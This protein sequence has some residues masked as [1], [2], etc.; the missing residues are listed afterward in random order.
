MERI[1][2]TDYTQLGKDEDVH[3]KTKH[4]KTDTYSST[5]VVYKQSKPNTTLV[6]GTYTVGKYYNNHV[7]PNTTHIQS[8]NTG[9]KEEEEQYRMWEPWNRQQPF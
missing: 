5:N 6:T 2:C 8:E 3:S 9:K 4:R 7:E 1:N